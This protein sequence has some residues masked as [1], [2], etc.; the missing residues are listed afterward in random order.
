MLE[1]NKHILED[2][3]EN[4]QSLSYN[5]KFQQQ[6]FREALSPK[7]I[8]ARFAQ[9][10]SVAEIINNNWSANATVSHIPS[11]KLSPHASLIMDQPLE[12]L[13]EEDI[14]QMDD[15][16]NLQTPTNSVN[17]TT[18]SSVGNIVHDIGDPYLNPSRSYSTISKNS[19]E[20]DVVVNTDKIDAPSSY[21][22]PWSAHLYN[23]QI[24]DKNEESI[25]QFLLMEDLTAGLE[26]PC[27]LDL[28]MGTRQHGVM[29]T[30]EKKT[31][32]ERK[33]DR[34]TSKRLGVRICG[35]QVIQN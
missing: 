33:C 31:S 11:P 25:Q 29:A 35:M 17:Y 27:I 2:L 4:S 20:E 23:T 8:R 7:G 9:L 16:A 14:F 1:H 32:Q 12:T 26:F 19:K 34:S 24:I 30:L 18:D 6:V 22:N 15:T 13:E 28:K 5:K 21:I 10:K 3:E